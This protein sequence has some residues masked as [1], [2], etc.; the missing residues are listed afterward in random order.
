MLFSIISESM[1]VY[2]KR[3]HFIFRWVV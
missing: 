2:W 3:S 1:F